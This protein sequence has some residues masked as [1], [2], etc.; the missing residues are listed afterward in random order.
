MSVPYQTIL[1]LLK[2][3]HSC[4]RIM[5]RRV[6]TADVHRKFAGFFLIPEHAFVFEIPR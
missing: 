1:L 5:S 3:R 6:F 4:R 2:A